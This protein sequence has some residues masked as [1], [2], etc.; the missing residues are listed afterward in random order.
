MVQLCKQKFIRDFNSLSGKND[1]ANP[2]NPHY[3]DSVKWSFRSSVCYNEDESLFIIFDKFKLVNKIM[4]SQFNETSV[5]TL[6]TRYAKLFDWQRASRLTHDFSYFLKYQ[7]R[8]SFCSEGF[9]LL[10]QNYYKGWLQWVWDLRRLTSANFIWRKN[11]ETN[12]SS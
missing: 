11:C 6:F 8:S 7:S 9:C 10:L 5:S 3:A 1:A 4:L 2:L 12:E